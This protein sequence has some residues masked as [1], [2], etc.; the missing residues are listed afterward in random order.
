MTRLIKTAAEYL[1]EF[2]SI[3]QLTEAVQFCR[4][5]DLYKR[6]TQAVFG[7]GPVAARVVMIG[8]QPGDQEDIQGHPF[9]GPAGKLLDRAL[10]DA[11]IDRADVYITNAVKHFKFE[12]RGKRRIHKKPS[13]TEVRACS[14][15]LEAELR[16]IRPEVVV[17]LGVTGAQAILGSGHRLTENR[18]KF[19]S[20]PWA[21]HVTA[22]VHPSAVLRAPD[23]DQRHAQYRAFVADL[24]KVR[25]LL[26]ERRRPAA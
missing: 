25:R 4:G 14:P 8:E 16:A 6:A 26:S 22:T 17:C 20:H 5:C 10:A 2:R 13:L 9:V 21:P 23:E 11:K 3:P 12:E 7:E 15:W 1:P 24:E 18:G 19:F